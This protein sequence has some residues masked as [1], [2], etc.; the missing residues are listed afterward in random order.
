MQEPFWQV[1]PVVQ[2]SLSLHD[3]PLVLIGFAGQLPPEQLAW[4]WHWS[5][6]GHCIP[7]PEV[8]TPAWH[9]SPLV[10]ELPS[11]HGVP[12]DLFGSLHSPVDGSQVPAVWH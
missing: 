4:M 5:A 12:L 8:H 1:S 6:G 3:V 2:A 9:V 7:A 10:H 11:S